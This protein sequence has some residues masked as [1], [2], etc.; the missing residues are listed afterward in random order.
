[1][2]AYGRSCA[3]TGEH[4]LPALEAAHIRAYTSD[5]P[6][7]V[8][9]GLLLRADFHRLLDLGYVTVTPDYRLEVSRRLK[10][11][12]Q[13]GKSYYPFHGAALILPAAANLRPQP[14]YLAWHRE[15]VYA[16]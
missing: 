1:M 4:S 10:D 12:Y 9:N 13:N 6:H 8:P 2:D 16:A 7:E 15:N 14:D 11:E 3:V 5:G